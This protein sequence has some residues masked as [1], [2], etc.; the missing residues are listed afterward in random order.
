MSILRFTDSDCPFD[1]FKLF[2][3]PYMYTICTMQYKNNQDREYTCIFSYALY[4]FSYKRK[5]AKYKKLFSSR[6]KNKIKIN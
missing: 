1:I 5:N 6:T 4:N 3:K 2:L